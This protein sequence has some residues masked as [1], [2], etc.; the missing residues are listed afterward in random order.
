[1]VPTEPYT[2]RSSGSEPRAIDGRRTD[3]SS[4]GLT[5]PHKGVR[6]CR[7]DRISV[8][9]HSVEAEVER[10]LE[11]LH[12]APVRHLL[13]PRGVSSPKHANPP[14]RP[15]TAETPPHD[16]PVVLG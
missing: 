2:R 10:L 12:T 15:H 1:M 5:S 11:A 8:L 13:G 14:E 9:S 16:G 7:G 3:R 6:R 4:G